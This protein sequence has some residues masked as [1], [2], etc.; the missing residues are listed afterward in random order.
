MTEATSSVR[1]ADGTEIG[2][3]VVGN[4]PPVIV[5]H[6]GTADRSRWTP[7]R[8]GLAERFTVYIVDRRGR[9]LSVQES[10]APY[11]V[12]R[13]GEDIAAVLESVG[14]PALLFGHSY[15]GLVALEAARLSTLV[16]GLLL[17]EPA[18]ATPGHVPVEDEVFARFDELLAAGRREVALEVFF[19]EVVGVPR[20]QIELMRGSAIW[21]ARLKVIHTAS[22]EGRAANAYSLDPAR[23]SAVA[24]PTTVLMGTESPAWLQAA[25]R[26]T[27]AALTGS[28]LVELEGQ[29]HMAIDTAPERIIGEVLTLGHSAFGE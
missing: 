17:Y 22:R 5:V 1:S 8:P 27:H 7:V 23:F 16:A 20:E 4:G 25:C 26:A 2:F 10:E 21:E 9:G 15:G 28:R 3:E 6:G 24:A 12:E 18:A 29:G 19:A 11:G 14:E 13:E